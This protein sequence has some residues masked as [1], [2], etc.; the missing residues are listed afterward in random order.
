MP[1]R[2]FLGY[3]SPFLPKLTSHLLQDRAALAETLVIV[4]T[5]QSGRILRESLAEN[6]TALL[7]PTV[8]TPG[9]LLH[10]EDPAIA[11]TWLEKIAWIESLESLATSD[12]EKLTG[13]F[14]KP[15]DTTS[16]NDWAISL[17]SEI[18][19]LRATL[20][21]HRHN[22]FSA[23]KFLTHTPEATRW[24]NLAALENLAEKQL[25]AWHYTSR[26]T[27]LRGNFSLP[28]GYKKIILAGVTEMPPCLARTFENYPGEIVVI[29]AAP[30][31]EMDHFSPLGI[32][33]GQ[34]AA[35][36]LPE[37][38][39]VNIAADPAQQ[40][41]LALETLA[42]TGATSSEIALGSA[43][44]QTGDILAR[45]LT[46]NG[47]S[48][49]HPAAAQPLPALVRWLHAWADWLAKPSSRHLAAL[50]DLPESSNLIGGFR[51]Q[52]LLRLNSLR[53]KH[54]TSEPRAL[55][56]LTSEKDATLNQTI[57]T[58]LT[59]RDSFLSSGFP[60]SIRAHLTALR[61]DG[62]SARRTA[63]QI[64][65]FLETATPVFVKIDRPH[66][67]WM[68]V[69]LSELPSPS[70]QPPTGRVIDI[71][72]WLELLYEPG[73]HL[74][75]CGMNETF[76][77]SRSGGEPWLSE[78]IR[79][80]LGLNSDSER[81]AR[82]AYLLHAMIKMREADGSTHLI[83]GKNGTG[84]ETY[85]PSRL[86]LQVARENLVSTVKNLFREIEPPEANLIWTRDFQWQTPAAELPERLSVTA[87]RGYLAC[88]FRF[89]LNNIVG[90]GA[91][92]PDRRE[93]NARDFGSVTHFVLE[94]WGNDLEARQLSDPEKLSAYLDA[95]LIEVIAHDFGKKIP[96]AIRIQ[97]QS[98]RQR[99]EWFAIEQANCAANGW[100]ILH[101]ERKFGIP[102]NGF[103]ISGKID[104]IDR[105]RE[106]G[107]L[108]V[109][110]YKTGKAEDTEKAHRQKITA[111]TRIPGHLEGKTAPFQSTTDAKG[112]PAEFFWKNL[113]LPLY[114]LAESLDSN[115]E[116]PI[117][118]YISLGQTEDNVKFT[119]WDTFSAEDLE[120]AKICTDWITASIADRNFWP[121]S[122]KVQY[123]DFALLSQHQPLTE[124]F[125]PVC[126]L[127]I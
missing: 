124:A 80:A 38:V 87:L 46:E 47:W 77:P 36:E 27:A 13:L 29:I 59:L 16:G 35:R 101:I 48:A 1:K 75:I 114:A 97:A 52:N 7:A 90:M 107:Q 30:E 37:H 94:C 91:T 56:D 76:V 19:S 106:T 81:H 17:A 66:G 100:E 40:A 110:D 89:Y 127:K 4:P 61:A 123:D 112:K 9:S 51:A 34:W 70:A 25:S 105:H 58:L 49:F 20:Q 69:L 23:S 53:D 8:A 118:T 73:K 72:G 45:T 119:T 24:E 79:K 10:L 65:D 3:D 96:L 122:E 28:Q 120:S 42:E 2:I 117:P 22:L 95:K 74:V 55:L 11:P 21:D 116:I 83:C 104:R 85:L 44:D 108:R 126:S 5:S 92:E 26:S 115:G 18:V 60:N 109:I 57:R 88:P 14:S 71:Q 62:E 39:R 111:S 98:I 15:P 68:N 84:G 82:D 63:S 102:S 64:D 31:S 67:F 6:A 78:T 43:D 54:P 93:M 86:L 125:Q 99:L 12:W 41:K 121:P 103:T 33:T 32:P 50:L 113:Q